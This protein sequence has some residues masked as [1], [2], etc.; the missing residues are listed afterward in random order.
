[1]TGLSDNERHLTSIA[2]KIAACIGCDALGGPEGGDPR[3]IMVVQLYDGRG[4]KS[5]Y[6]VMY[7]RRHGLEIGHSYR[8][9]VRKLRNIY[10]SKKDRSPVT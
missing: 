2:A 5:V 1:M 4:E 6:C 10:A 3:N 8:D 9:A 7:G